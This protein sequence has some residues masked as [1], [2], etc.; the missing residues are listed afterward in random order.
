MVV[1]YFRTR[2]RISSVFGMQ[3]DCFPLAVQLLANDKNGKLF[4][5]DSLEKRV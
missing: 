3:L 2:V 4:L 1:I 5:H